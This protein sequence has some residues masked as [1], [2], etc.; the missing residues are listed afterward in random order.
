MIGKLQIGNISAAYA[1]TSTMFF[2]SV[3]HDPFEKNVDE[4]G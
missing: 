1:D 4:G 3:R 2:Q